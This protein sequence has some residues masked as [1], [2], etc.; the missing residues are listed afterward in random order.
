MD[1]IKV[2]NMKPS[3]LSGVDAGVKISTPANLIKFC[4][5]NHKFFG[6]Y[7]NKTL[8]ICKN[9]PKKILL[10]ICPLKFSKTS[11]KE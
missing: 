1:L 2:I 6:F 3:H 10:Q 8:E 4:K 7:I 5:N 11:L 9:N